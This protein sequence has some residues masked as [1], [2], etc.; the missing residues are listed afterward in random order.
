[1]YATGNDIIIDNLSSS[2]K[3]N[4]RGH[5]NLINCIAVSSN[6]LIASGQ[7]AAP[8][9]ANYDSPVIIWRSN[10]TDLLARLFGLK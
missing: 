9:S 6:Q 8:G 4:L 1:M 7:L 3:I 2:N 10:S 5:D